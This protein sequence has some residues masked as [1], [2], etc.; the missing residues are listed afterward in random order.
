MSNV[1]DF[2][3]GLPLIYILLLYQCFW[4]FGGGAGAQNLLVAVYNCHAPKEPTFL[5][6][7]Y[8]CNT[9]IHARSKNNI[10]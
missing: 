2:I 8:L 9:N 1:Y 4:W 7:G 10:Q 6:M 3:F 5:K